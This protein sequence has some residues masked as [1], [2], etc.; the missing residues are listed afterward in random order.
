M[1]LTVAIDDLHPEKGWGLEGDECMFYLEELNKEFG[2]K[3]TLF[4]P[5]NYHNKFPLSQHKYW[6]DWLLS[7]DYFELAAH[8]HYHMTSDKQAW[9]EC[10][11][12]DIQ[13]VEI[14]KERISLMINEWESVNYKPKG[15]RNPGWLCQPFC[16]NPL[17]ETFEYA[18]VHYE[19]NRG[20]NWSCKMLF[21]HDG[22]HETDIKLHNDVLMF[23]SHIAGD[24]NQNVWNKDNYEQFR[25]SLQFISD[26]YSIE[27]LF[28]KEL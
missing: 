3:F 17:S 16:V 26:N 21:G 10:E 2:V 27:P 14:C 8:G 6:I 7:K 4:I 23:Q 24:W 11:F 5:S 9:G 1:K 25:S 18:A 20:M 12:A 28:L 22:I 13:T 19:H 15:W